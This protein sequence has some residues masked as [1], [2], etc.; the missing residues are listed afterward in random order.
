MRCN[1]LKSERTPRAALKQTLAPLD[2]GLPPHALPV[3]ASGRTVDDVVPSAVVPI[4]YNHVILRRVHLLGCTAGFLS[5][6]AE[7]K[8]KNDVPE[9]PCTTVSIGAVLAPR[10]EVM[11]ASDA[12]PTGAHE[13]EV[14]LATKE[15]LRLAS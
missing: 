15:L 3:A 10:T 13:R 1:K 14:V 12:L 7:E 11:T 4:V 5:A 6:R 2:L 8:L 9:E